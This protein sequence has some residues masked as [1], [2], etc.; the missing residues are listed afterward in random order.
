[1]RRVPENNFAVIDKFGPGKHGFGPG[2]KSTGTLATIPGADFMNSVQEEIA[3]LLEQNGVVLKPNDNTQ[4]YELIKSMLAGKVNNSVVEDAAN[5]GSAVF[6][7]AQGRPAGLLGGTFRGYPEGIG[8]VQ[9]ENH[10]PIGMTGISR[11]D[12][13]TVRLD[14]AQEFG[15]V[16]M[17]VT[18]ADETF[19]AMGVI[20]GCSVD[21]G[22]SLVKNV[23]PLKFTCKGDGSI[24]RISPL[25]AGSVEFSAESDPAKGVL[26]FKHPLKSVA[27]HQAIVSNQTYTDRVS[28]PVDI[29]SF[30]NDGGTEVFIHAYEEVEE[31]VW[32]KGTGTTVVVQQGLNKAAYTVAMDAVSG[33]ITIT[34]PAVKT[35][36]YLTC[37]VVMPFKNTNRFVIQSIG[38]TQTTLLCYNTAGTVVKTMEEANISFF[39]QITPTKRNLQ[40]AAVTAENEFLVDLGLCHDPVD[41]FKNVPAGNIWFTGAMS[42]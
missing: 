4:L 8:F 34:H 16:G 42:K 39:F 24:T 11:A 20:S 28:K 21:A 17:M 30:N 35:G 22:Y 38:A 5:I 13:Y 36:A 31:A 10:R 9:D 18:G 27:A 25:F 19:A 32:I 37:P 23:A 29:A 2:N 14:H 26:R 7:P 33:L 15:R 12:N 3:Q 1:M 6:V 41:N 40:P